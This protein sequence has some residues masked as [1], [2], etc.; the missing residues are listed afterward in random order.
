VGLAQSARQQ[1]HSS[2]DGGRSAAKLTERS[3]S[4]DACND[5]EASFAMAAAAE[6]MVF[7]GPHARA[8]EGVGNA[9]ERQGPIL[10]GIQMTSVGLACSQER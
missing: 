3:P 6:H 5:S 1:L 9:V 7:R 4:I 10:L 8:G 2:G